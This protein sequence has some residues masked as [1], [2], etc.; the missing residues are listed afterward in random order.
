MVDYILMAS[1]TQSNSA[2][3]LGN[4]PEHT[5]ETFNA[6]AVPADHEDQFSNA[7]YGAG[8]EYLVDPL[9]DS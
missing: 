4:G 3:G 2:N 8:K 1:S 5:F 9:L 7:Q 6:F